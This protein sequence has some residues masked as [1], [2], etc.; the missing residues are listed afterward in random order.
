M[1]ESIN[2]SL[3]IKDPYFH[4]FEAT[5]SGELIE[6]EGRLYPLYGAYV[7]TCGLVVNSIG[8]LVIP[9]YMDL[10]FPIKVIL[11]KVNTHHPIDFYFYK[12]LVHLL[13]PFEHQ[14]N[15]GSVHSSYRAMVF[16]NDPSFNFQYAYVN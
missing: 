5:Y 6:H 4:V 7:S 1:S 13:Y 8:M 9:V 15:T 14:T 2:E 12:R 16:V 11:G 10:Y 3:I